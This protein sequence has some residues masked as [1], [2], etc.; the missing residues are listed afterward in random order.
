MRVVSGTARGTTLRPVP[1]DTTRPIL[2]RVKTALFDV[3]RPSLAGT[4]ILDLF[5]G[6]GSIGIEALSQGAAHC[7][8]LDLEPRATK[9][10]K[11]NLSATRLAEK[12]EVRTTDAFTYLRNTSKSFDI[13]FVA[14]PQY[15]SLWIEAMHFISERPE[16]TKGEGLVVV[17]I[18]PKE[19]EKLELSSFEEYEQRKYGNTLLVFFKRV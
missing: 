18:D 12:A 2:D 14:P 11:E 9:T 17:Q 6:S 5:G 7:V 16:I 15:K 1:G 19:Y 8:F 13:I 3:L 4:E 10:I